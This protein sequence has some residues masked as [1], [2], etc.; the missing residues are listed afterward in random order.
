[1][2]IPEGNLSMSCFWLYPLL[3]WLQQ[4]Q[5]AYKIKSKY[6]SKNTREAFKFTLWSEPN[7]SYTFS[8]C[9]LSNRSMIQKIA[10]LSWIC[11]AT[12]TVSTA[13]DA[14]LQMV[15]LL[16]NAVN[17]FLAILCH[18][19]SFR[20]LF[21]FCLLRIV[22]IEKQNRL[23]PMFHILLTFIFLLCRAHSMYN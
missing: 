11:P 17:E 3:K 13:W 2:H 7:S 9:S 14:S 15:S 18:L 5:R 20:S 19:A 22:F 21:R 16:N 4:F 8:G 12:S 23:A 10:W 6:L 1:M